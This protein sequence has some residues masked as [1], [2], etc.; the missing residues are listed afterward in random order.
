[1][2]ETLQR[3][4]MEKGSDICILE[5]TWLSYHQLGY[6]SAFSAALDM[7]HVPV[8]VILILCQ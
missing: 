1:M 4:R 2:I 3:M 5:P 6:F 7:P 8:L